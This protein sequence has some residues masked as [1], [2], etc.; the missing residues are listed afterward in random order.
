MKGGLLDSSFEEMAAVVSKNSQRGVFTL[1]SETSS[2]APRVT[3]SWI[4]NFTSSG[5]LGSYSRN[6]SVSNTGSSFRN[7]MAS[8]VC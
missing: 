2:I 8:E 6:C 7:L 5:R 4:F 3:N 1:S